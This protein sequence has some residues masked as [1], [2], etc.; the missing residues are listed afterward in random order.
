[1]LQKIENKLN[2]NLQLLASDEGSEGADSTVDNTEGTEGQEQQEKTFTQADI[3]KIVNERLAREKKKIE[4]ANEEKYQ[5][6]LKAEL[7]E[8]EKLAKMNEADR[9]KAKAEKERKAFEAEKARYLEERKEFEQ[10]KIKTQTMQM[11]GERNMPVEL[12]KFIQSNTA[13]EIM[14]NVTVF[15]K[16]FNEAVEKLVNERLKGRTPTTSTS[17]KST[18]N[19]YSK[20]TWSLQK[21]MELEM[22]NPSLAQQLKSQAK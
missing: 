22:S 21:Q 20:D 8:S 12:A 19:P 5:A 6:Q 11:L 10:A 15:E 18:N 3:D 17:N 14:D 2:M 7:E 9:L 13:D 16:C 4:K 1:M